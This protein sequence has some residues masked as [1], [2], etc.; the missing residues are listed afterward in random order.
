MGIRIVSMCIDLMDQ[1]I[2]PD[3]V[4]C[5]CSLSGITDSGSD[6]TSSNGSADDRCTDSGGDNAL[7]VHADRTQLQVF[8]RSSLGKRS[9]QWNIT[10]VLR[11]VQFAN[12]VC[13][14]QCRCQHSMVHTL[15]LRRSLG[16]RVSPC[17]FCRSHDQCVPA[18]ADSGSDN[19]SSNGSADDRCADS[20]SDNTSS[21]GSADDRCADSGTDA[22]PDNASTNT[23]SYALSYAAADALSNASADT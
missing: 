17:R 19:T 16:A 11:L 13:G 21:N 20:G 6:N 1:D 10:G 2:L 18:G 15:R 12:R 8:G 23:L 4:P 22:Q 7:R 5:I 3:N 9:E 14:F